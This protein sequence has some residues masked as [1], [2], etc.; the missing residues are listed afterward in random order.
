MLQ[1]TLFYSASSNS[2]NHHKL[3][4][5]NSKNN[6]SPK[7]TQSLPQPSNPIHH[8]LRATPFHSNNRDY[9]MAFPISIRIHHH[10]TQVTPNSNHH[11]HTIL[12]INCNSSKPSNPFKR[13]A[14]EVIPYTHQMVRSTAVT[15]IRISTTVISLMNDLALI[16]NRSHRSKLN[17]CSTIITH[18]ITTH[19]TAVE[20]HTTR[21]S[22]DQLLRQLLFQLRRRNLWT[23]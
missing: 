5:N 20:M 23:R 21:I 17:N 22:V 3:Q 10:P 4:N 14:E 12:A 1:A 19:T 7:L 18:E 8:I 11:S 16:N 9:H 6:Q 13:V 2:L 15:A